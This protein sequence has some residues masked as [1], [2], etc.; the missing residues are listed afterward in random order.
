MEQ[1]Q[2]YGTFGRQV[3]YVIA[4]NIAILLL[5]LVQI[6]ILT[7]GLG[8]SLYGVWSLIN[9]TVSLIVPFAMVSFSVS[10]VRFLAAEKDEG[11]IR[12]DF[13]SA[14]S[15]V[16]ISGIVFSVLLFF[17]SDFLA[18]SIFKDVNSSSY[19]KLASVLIL[20]NSLQALPLAFFRMRRRIGLYTILSL[21][22][23]AFQV[24][25]IVLF[26]LLGYKLTGVIIAVIISGILFDLI[27]LL[28][29]FRQTGLQ[30]PRFSH[31]KSYLRWGVPLT[32]NSALLWIINIS[33]RYMVSYFL[34]VAAAGIYNAAYSIGYYASFALMPLGTVLYPSISKYYDGGNLGQTRNYLSY[35]VKYLMMV[36]I[37]S[38]FG[39]SILAKPLLQIL[40][41]AEF[42]AGIVVVP[43]VA[44]G[45]VLFCFY[46]VC[47]YII[48][49]V[50]K[51]RITVRL[52][53]TAAVLNIGLNL[54]LIPRM[55]I[56]GAAVATLV[57]YGVLGMLTLLVT[58]RYL[59]FDLSLPFIAKSI[60][61]SGIMALCIWLINPQSL[62]AVLL[63]IVLGTVIYFAVLWAIK[64]LSKV[65]ITFFTNFIKGN[66]AKIGL[67]KE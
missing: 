38:A 57:A 19:I 59:K 50:G 43:W 22:Y 4:A 45:A 27:A 31:M 8:T 46:Q 6:P 40:A 55:G 34:G 15:I 2:E 63:S 16:F 21:S 32:P 13:L 56:V 52:L 37:P 33:D 53:G 60:F 11:R 25:L 66:F 49:L 62:R 14:C 28:I 58:R 1:T 30:V 48:H 41:T 51:T 18:A 17:L 10:I 47:V 7:K 24:G 9:V 67:F 44:F 61:S 12:E 5:G 20:L 3:G 29:T 42:V 39:L 36:A 26:I 35:S 65:E 23:Q 54:L 64:G